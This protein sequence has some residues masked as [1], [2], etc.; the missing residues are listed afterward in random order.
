MIT[1]MLPAFLS[2]EFMELIPQQ[3]K[4]ISQ[5]FDTGIINGYSLSTDRSKLWVVM[6]CKNEAEV[7]ATMDKFPI[8]EYVEYTVNEL[9]FHESAKVIVPAISMN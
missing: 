2:G 3:R 7:H 9:M 4:Y 1:V 6:L 8:R 5:M